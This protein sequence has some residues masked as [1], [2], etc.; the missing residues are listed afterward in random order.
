MLSVLV[1]D[2]GALVGSIEVSAFTV[3]V[4]TVVSKMVDVSSLTV[5]VV[6]PSVFVELDKSVGCALLEVLVESV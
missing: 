3:V 4:E 5:D 6:C 1:D 2:A